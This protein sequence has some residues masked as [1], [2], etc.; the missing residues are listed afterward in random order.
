MLKK[1]LIMIVLLIF[2]TGC[3]G[4]GTV[5][6][7]L[8]V[9]VSDETYTATIEGTACKL[10]G[11]TS[12]GGT[13][14]LDNCV[15]SGTA[16]HADNKRIIPFKVEITDDKDVSTVHEMHLTVEPRPISFEL[17]DSITPGSAGSGYTHSFQSDPKYGNPPYTFTVSGQPMGLFMSLNGVLSG[18]IPKGAT[19][20]TYTLQVCVKDL[21][22]NQACDNTGLKVSKQESL[23][24]EMDSATCSVIEEYGTY[25]AKVLIEVSGNASGPVGS[26]LMISDYMES[27]NMDCGSWTGGEGYDDCKRGGEDPATTSWSNSAT[28]LSEVGAIER[29][30][31]DV[32]Y[33]GIPTKY[34]SKENIQC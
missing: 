20:K 23:S 16:P 11:A 9:A 21:S 4:T 5:P 31:V 12:I 6:G 13:L 15:I 30:A 28:K 32:A 24:V 19:D 14:S 26:V 1:T 10:V 34:S 29:Y 3:G 18:T 8:P 22:G 2:I 27:V 25:G 7:G 17:P 33:P